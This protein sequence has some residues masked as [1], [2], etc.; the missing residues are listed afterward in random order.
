MA[1]RGKRSGRRINAFRIRESGG[2]YSS[3]NGRCAVRARRW[4]DRSCRDGRACRGNRFAMSPR[5]ALRAHSRWCAH[6]GGAM[7]RSNMKSNASFWRLV[8]LMNSA[9]RPAGGFQCRQRSAL[10]AGSG[11]RDNALNRAR[12]DMEQRFQ[13]GLSSHGMCH[14]VDG[15]ARCSDLELG[16]NF[17]Q[18]LSGRC[19]VPL[20]LPDQCP[21]LPAKGNGQALIGMTHAE[22]QLTRPA[23]RSERTVFGMQ[24]H[25]AAMRAMDRVP[26]QIFVPVDH[27]DHGA[28]TGVFSAKILAEAAS[29]AVQHCFFTFDT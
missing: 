24:R 6:R 26:R 15:A 17:G 5:W 13:G 10:I 20:R 23:R 28:S 1:V 7:S 22:T 12:L 16:H 14:D 8:T 4:A 9:S 19:C 2:A 11:H 29:T 25:D 27:D 3:T 21:R 18:R